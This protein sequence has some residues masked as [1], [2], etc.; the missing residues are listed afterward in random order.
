VELPQLAD[1]VALGAIEVRARAVP[2]AEVT[3]AW[4]ADSNERIVLVP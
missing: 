3:P 2:L 4:I 1:A